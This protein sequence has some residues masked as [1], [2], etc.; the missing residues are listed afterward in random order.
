[1]IENT[2][3]KLAEAQKAWEQSSFNAYK[4]LLNENGLTSLLI[5]HIKKTGDL[6]EVKTKVLPNNSATQAHISLSLTDDRT[7]IR[8]VVKDL[9]FDA[10]RNMKKKWIYLSTKTTNAIE[11]YHIVTPVSKVSD[12]KRVKDKINQ[13]GF[14]E[15]V[16]IKGFKNK[17][18][19]I[20]NKFLPRS[21][22]RKIILK[23][24]ES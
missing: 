18:L 16:E 6:Y 11:I 8:K 19:V 3:V 22:S 1:M 10:F 14:A 24:N 13:L 7:D 20:G 9:V 5:L 12:L 2:P 4:K 17:L 23:T 21:I 15:Q